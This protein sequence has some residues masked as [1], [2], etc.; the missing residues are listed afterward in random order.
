MIPI[1]TPMATTSRIP[2]NSE[3]VH[4]TCKRDYVGLDRIFALVDIRYQSVKW[5]CTVGEKMAYHK[6]M[7]VAVSV[8]NPLVRHS[9]LVE[10]REIQNFDATC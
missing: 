9:H 2:N 4:V 7:C 3:Q 5:G 1:A 8:D 6:G 10:K